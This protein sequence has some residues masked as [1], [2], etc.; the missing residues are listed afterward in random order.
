M[1][2]LQ[3]LENDRPGVL[4]YLPLPHISVVITKN[5]VASS[6]YGNTEVPSLKITG[7]VDFVHY[8]EFQ[9]YWVP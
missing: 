4:E 7:L 2:Y 6:C 8:L 9:L 3:F 5:G 1:H